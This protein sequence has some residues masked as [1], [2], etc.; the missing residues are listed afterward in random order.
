MDE[1]VKVEESLDFSRF[2]FISQRRHDD[3]IP[4]SRKIKEK[5]KTYVH[6]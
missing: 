6:T 4:Y 1:V 2:L 5:K 3:I